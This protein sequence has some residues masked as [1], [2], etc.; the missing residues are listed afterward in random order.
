[1]IVFFSSSDYVEKSENL[2]FATTKIISN[3]ECARFY[4]NNHDLVNSDV[5]C[6]TNDDSKQI[7]GKGD[8]GA[9]LVI[10]E[11]GYNTLIGLLSF[12]Y[13]NLGCGRQSLPIAFTRITSHLGWITSVTNYQMRS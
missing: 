5:I 12:S 1:M 13:K 7:A 4:Q 9:P 11:Y 8:T 3:Q 6:A 2:R 10:N